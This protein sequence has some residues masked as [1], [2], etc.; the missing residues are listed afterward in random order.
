MALSTLPTP[1]QKNDRPEVIWEILDFK[2]N[3]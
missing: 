3:F 1:D 2:E